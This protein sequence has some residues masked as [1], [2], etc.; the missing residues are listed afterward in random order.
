MGR[1][2]GKRRTRKNGKVQRRRELKI[3]YR[4]YKTWTKVAKRKKWSSY[5]LR[6]ERSELG[7]IKGPS[8]TRK[9]GRD[10][11]A[12]RVEERSVKRAELLRRKPKT[13]RVRSPL[14]TSIDTKR[15]VSRV[16]KRQSVRSVGEKVRPKRV[17]FYPI[18][19]SSPTS[20]DENNNIIRHFVQKSGNKD[21]QI[22]GFLVSTAQQWAKDRITGRVQFTDNRGVAIT[23]GTIVGI[24]PKDDE[25]IFDIGFSRNENSASAW[26][27]KMNHLKNQL[28]AQKGAKNFIF[29]VRDSETYRCTDIRI[30]YSFA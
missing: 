14:A 7:F 2:T 21:K 23:E 1:K 13:K 10:G 4:R 24:L 12:K 8:L 5:R 20:I 30:T 22:E 29:D 16:R 27:R 25:M 17:I 26:R 3:L 18:P 19:Q 11:S 15:L 6:K 28:V 9:L